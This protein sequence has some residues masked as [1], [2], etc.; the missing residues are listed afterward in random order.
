MDK[1][2]QKKVLIKVW[3]NG[4]KTLKKLDSLFKKNAALV[5]INSDLFS[6][7]HLSYVLPEKETHS[8]PY[9]NIKQTKTSSILPSQIPLF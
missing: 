3:I 6:G 7:W 9:E 4:Y 8:I 2:A 5:S 1:K